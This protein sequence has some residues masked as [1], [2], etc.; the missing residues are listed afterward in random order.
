LATFG[1]EHGYPDLRGGYSQKYL[2]I[3]IRNKGHST[4]HNCQAQLR[5]VIP[6]G[7]NP[8]L[9]P[10]K[11]A[12]ELTWGRSPDKSDISKQIDI[13]PVI[14]E[15]L[16]HAVFSDSRFR[17]IPTDPNIPTRFASISIF[18]RLTH[19]RG[20]RVEDSFSLGYFV[21][22]V[23]VSSNETYCRA[24]FRIQVVEHHTA[25]EMRKLTR[26]ENFKLRFFKIFPRGILY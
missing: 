23:L 22:D 25:I 18:D 7:A 12:K 21:V 3:R 5:V 8:Q 2:R 17:F 16:L 20:L 10:S 15:A 9:H 26:L 13:H 1:P 6:K 24:K 11:D 19:N 14:G 4:A